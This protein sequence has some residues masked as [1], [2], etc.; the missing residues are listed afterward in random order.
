MCNVNFGHVITEGCIYSGTDCA[1]GV[2]LLVK[3]SCKWTPKKHFITLIFYSISIKS[4]YAE[5]DFSKKD[6]L[7]LGLLALICASLLELFHENQRFCDYFVK[8]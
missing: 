1:D 4:L 7:M 6:V 2:S 8:R 5:D 3:K